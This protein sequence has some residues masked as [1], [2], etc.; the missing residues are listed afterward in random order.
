MDFGPETHEFQTFLQD[1]KQIL[2]WNAQ[3]ENRRQK[4][5]HFAAYLVS[6]RNSLILSI[7]SLFCQFH[8]CKYKRYS[9]YRISCISK[10]TTNFTLHQ[11]PKE[12]L[13][14]EFHVFCAFPI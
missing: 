4:F 8:C 13:T 3:I 12:I 6:Y 14:T 1:S 10:P 9:H 11:M 7:S 5:V 2:W